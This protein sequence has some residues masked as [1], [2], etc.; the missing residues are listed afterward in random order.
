MNVAVIIIGVVTL[1]LVVKEARLSL[2]QPLFIVL[3]IFLVLWKT[4]VAIKENLV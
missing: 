1:L 3:H 4:E 2:V